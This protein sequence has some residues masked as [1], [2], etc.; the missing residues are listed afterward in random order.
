[1]KTPLVRETTGS[2][3]IK[4]TSLPKK[5]RALSP[6]SAKLEIE[7]AEERFKKHLKFSF[8]PPPLF[9]LRICN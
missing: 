4:S 8:S 7:Y 2:H 6:V 3:L 9:D 1:M 5:V